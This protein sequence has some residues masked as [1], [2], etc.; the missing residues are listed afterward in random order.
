MSRKTG[1]LSLDDCRVQREQF[2]LGVCAK[3]QLWLGCP[4]TLSS[5]DLWWWH[6]S[7]HVCSDASEPS[8]PCH[9]FLHSFPPVL[10]F[11]F[12]KEQESVANTQRVHVSNRLSFQKSCLCLL[13]QWTYDPFP[14]EREGSQHEGKCGIHSGFHFATVSQHQPS[15]W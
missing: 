1:D 5:D 14:V 4:W 15:E 11:T 3:S 9:I 7:Q 8:H 2:F 6:F 12:S 10:L 13:F